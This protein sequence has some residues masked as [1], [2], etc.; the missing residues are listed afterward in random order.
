MK[1]PNLPLVQRSGFLFRFLGWCL[2]ALVVGIGLLHLMFRYWLLPD[3]D[4]YRNE[5]SSAITQASGQHV[6]IGSISAN[7]VGIYPHL[8]LRKVQIHNK[9]G[10]AALVLNRLE[11]IPAWSSLLSGEL[12]FRKIKIDQPNLTVHLDSNGDL[13]V[14]GIAMGRDQVAS[15]S[16]FLDWLLNQ[17]QVDV[18]NAHIFWKDEKNGT[19]LLEL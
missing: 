12:R 19:P 8:I 9:E 1:L 4:N 14:A 13:H 15:Q 11:S 5:I 17:R 7:W 16:G 10:R 3:I 2:L 6:T 18:V